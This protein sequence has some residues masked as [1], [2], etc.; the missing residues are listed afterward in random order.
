MR[1]LFLGAGGVG[2]Y[3]GGRL[4]RS[5]AD[6]T[7]LV[8]PTRAAQLAE[9]LKIQSPL[10]DAIVPVKTITEAD[11]AEPF[12]IIALACKAYGLTGALEAIA[13]HVRHGTV[14]M[15]LLNGLSHMAAIERRFPDAVIW[16]GIAQIPASLAA[17]GT[18]LHMG[19]LA[20]MVIGPRAGQQTSRPLAEAL[21]AA[22]KEAGVTARFTEEPIQELW[23]KWVY[24][25]TLAASTCLMRADIGTILQT[26][27]GEKLLNGLLDECVAVATAEGCA[28]PEP[29]M[30]MYRGQLSDRDS[31]WTA[32]MLRD[33]QAGGPTEADHILGEMIRLAGRYGIATPYLEVALTHLQVDL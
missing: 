33:L 8:R 11:A 26:D 28:P 14:I 15:P 13:P 21:V 27:Y 29:Q 24:L 9:G 6:V 2:G 1:V 5:G 20:G 4:V 19:K 3:F 31:K 18:V 7:F 23:N 32:S 16:G 12:D 17:D 25:A 10:G 30:T 22:L